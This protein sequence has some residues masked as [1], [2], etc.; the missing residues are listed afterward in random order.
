[1]DIGKNWRLLAKNSM[2][3][4]K[5][6]NATS[7][8]EVGVSVGESLCTIL[9]IFPTFPQGHLRSWSVG[10]SY[11]TPLAKPAL[12]M[13]V[14]EHTGEVVK[15]QVTRDLSQAISA[16]KDGSCIIWDVSDLTHITRK[17]ILHATWSLVSAIYHPTTEC[18]VPW[19]YTLL[20]SQN[21]Y[22]SL[23]PLIDGLFRYTFTSN[24]YLYA[25]YFQIVTLA[26]DGQLAYWE[27]LDGKE[28]R[29]L[30]MGKHS[31]VTALDVSPDGQTFCT[32]TN[33]SVIKAS[34]VQWR[35]SGHVSASL[36]FPT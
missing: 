32:A 22:F 5:K 3:S 31:T 1:M 11:K 30:T 36:S 10:H 26:Q 34:T 21:T 4:R 33:A 29:H 28:I 15:L 16:G 18:Q 6:L 20:I 7:W 9:L 12:K 23:F 14:K 19:I 24:A 35:Y 27:V 17:Q 2:I 8:D 13:T 25:C